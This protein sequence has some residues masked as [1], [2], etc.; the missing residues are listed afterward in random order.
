MNHRVS[1]HGLSID[2]D[3]FA[4][5]NDQ[6]LPQTGID[7]DTF[8]SG[9]SDLISELTPKN[10]AL[11]ARREELETLINE[12]HAERRGTPHDPKSYRAFLYD[13][14]YLAPE[15]PDFSVSTQGVDPEITA[16]PGPQLPRGGDGNAISGNGMSHGMSD[17]SDG[18][19]EAVRRY[20]PAL[21]PLCSGIALRRR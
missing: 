20:N 13:I 16:I 2:R 3:L 17:P 14:G 7:P 11:L 1:L 21:A 10:R 9:F 19:G 8:W 5:V 18:S 12:W 6:A 4:L 15:G